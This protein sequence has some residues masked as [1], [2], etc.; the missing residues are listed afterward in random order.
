MWPHCVLIQSPR[1]GPT[2]RS[3]SLVQFRVQVFIENLHD[4]VRRDIC[5]WMIGGTDHVV[6]VAAAATTTKICV[7]VRIP[8]ELLL[9]GEHV[10]V[11][12]SMW[13]GHPKMDSQLMLPRNRAGTP[14]H[15]IGRQQ[16]QHSGA[17]LHLVCM[18]GSPSIGSSRNL[19]IGFV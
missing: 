6:V 5:E 8:C 11:Q 15:S 17:A 4:R 18:Q 10:G 9:L 12:G 2:L 19:L 1:H 7:L 13:R 14:L 3:A 16:Q